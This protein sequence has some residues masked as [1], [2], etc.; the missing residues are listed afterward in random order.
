MYIY[1]YRERERQRHFSLLFPVWF[2][3]LNSESKTQS[4]LSTLKNLRRCSADIQD[5]L[6][7]L[8]FI[9]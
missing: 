7:F 3:R 6:A 4:T 8:V 9:D 2:T 5:K 1:I